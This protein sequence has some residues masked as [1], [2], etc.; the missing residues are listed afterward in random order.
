M[1]EEQ[2]PSSAIALR[3]QSPIDLTRD[4][5]RGGRP[6]KDAV[7][8]VLYGDFLCPYCR[9]LRPILL[10][11]RQALGQKMGFVFRHFF[12]ETNHPG[13]TFM[14]RAAEAAARQGRFWEMYDRFYE[15][16]NP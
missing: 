6:G 1:A 12:N 4:H 5:L 11:L 7:E 3:L 8:V 13:A 15:Q 9:R 14:A 10:R 2:A 16:Q